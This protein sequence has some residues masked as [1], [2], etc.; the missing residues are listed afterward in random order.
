MYND[1]ISNNTIFS[2]DSPSG[3]GDHENYFHKAEK[4]LDMDGVKVF[5]ECTKIAA[6]VRTMNV[7]LPWHSS[8][9]TFLFSKQS[10]FYYRG[11]EIAIKDI[12]PNEAEEVASAIEYIRA[13]DP[14][15]GY[16]SH[17]FQKVKLL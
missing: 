6:T 14:G 9:F 13:L 16:V 3:T 11:Q 15:Y 10:K 17:F 12:N 1:E 4:V 5:K 2:I 8:G 7:H